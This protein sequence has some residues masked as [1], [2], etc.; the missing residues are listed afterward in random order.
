MSKIR[1]S[2]GKSKL[3][4]AMRQKKAMLRLM[5][6]SPESP[7]ACVPNGTRR[8]RGQA[9][10]ARNARSRRARRSPCARPRHRRPAHQDIGIETVQLSMIAELV[11]IGQRESYIFERTVVAARIAYTAQPT[12]IR[13]YGC[14]IA[15]HSILCA[16]PDQKI[17][18][19][20]VAFEPARKDRHRIGRHGRSGI[21]PTAAGTNSS[22]EQ[23]HDYGNRY[24]QTSEHA[25]DIIILFPHTLCGRTI[26]LAKL[27]KMSEYAH[28]SALL[29]YRLTSKAARCCAGGVRHA[30]GRYRPDIAIRSRRAQC[31]FRRKDH[32]MKS[33]SRY[34]GSG[35]S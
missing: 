2:G 35:Q 28:S 7:P 6:V 30:A 11:G 20:V 29:P 16:Q 1:I 18:V 10:A 23:R 25:E 26:P 32:R 24:E 33:S 5:R 4:A 19:V 14:K 21:C 31:G 3:R 17:G 27:K 9:G 12:G 8:A 34:L 22:R 15:A 13:P